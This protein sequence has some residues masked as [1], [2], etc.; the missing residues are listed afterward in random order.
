MKSIHH[1]ITTPSSFHH[2]PHARENSMNYSEEFEALLT[3]PKLVHYAYCINPEENEDASIFEDFEIGD[4]PNNPAEGDMYSIA[5][6]QCDDNHH[7]MVA[8]IP[9]QSARYMEALAKKIG[10]IISDSAH[11]SSELRF[12]TLFVLEKNPE[13]V[14]VIPHSHTLQ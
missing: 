1:D 5:R 4:F 9:I 8:S 7:W 13:Y 12:P 3:D 14:D 2:Y 6:I 10:F 11:A